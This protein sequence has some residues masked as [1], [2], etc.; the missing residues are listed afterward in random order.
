MDDIA[1]DDFAFDTPHAPPPPPPPAMGQSIKAPGRPKTD[2]SARQASDERYAKIKAFED[3]MPKQARDYRFAIY[4]AKSGIDAKEGY[5]PLERVLASDW[6]TIGLADDETLLEYLRDKHGDGRFL[7]EPQ[8]AH[9]HR[10]DRLPFWVVSTHEDDEDMHSDETFGIPRGRRG[11]GRRRPRPSYFEDDL[12]YD[13]DLF[14]DEDPVATRSNHIDFLATQS[15]IQA[16]ERQATVKSSNDMMNMMMMLNEQRMTQEREERRREEERRSR[17]TEERRREEIRREELRQEEIKR[18]DEERRDY[19]R[20]E[21]RRDQERLQL[22]IEASSKKMEAMVALATAGL[23]VIQKMLQPTENPLMAAVVSKVMTDDGKKDTDPLTMML[24]KSILEKSQGNDSIQQ[25]IAGMGEMSKL[26]AQSM[27]EQMKL[28]FSTSN[29]MNTTLMKSL[30]ERA[31]SMAPEGSEEKG[32]F[33]QI[34]EAISG[35][36]GIIGSLAG[37]GQQQ[38]QQPQPGQGYFPQGGRPSQALPPGA[39]IQAPTQQRQPTPQA[40]QT[41]Q[42][43]PQPLDVGDDQNVPEPTGIAA[44]GAS[45]MAI[46]KELPR[47]AEELQGYVNFAIANMPP[48]LKQAIVNGDQSSIIAICSTTFL[49]EAELAQWI[50]EPGVSDW[51]M[52]FIPNLVP[53]IQAIDRMQGQETYQPLSEPGM[54]AIDDV[55]YSEPTLVDS[56]EHVEDGEGDQTNGNDSSDDSTDDNDPI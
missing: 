44:V 36:S 30:M 54:A 24:M 43:A 33:G 7:I 21:R 51:L 53:S 20:E 27:A 34:L 10:I 16:E 17:E 19:E 23:P 50:S 32:M 15:R 5:R 3:Q 4:Q 31:L 8:D 56:G 28:M 52:S 47:N 35:A 49:E 22:Q 12:D 55:L 40:H 11:R 25:M 13:P 39:P 48:Q 26:S 46:Q 18:R 2:P 6:A 14:E 1:S 45:L 38:Q 41:H 42:Q 9:N 37:G 29:E